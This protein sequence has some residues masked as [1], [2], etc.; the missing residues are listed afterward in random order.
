MVARDKRI[1][2]GTANLENSYGSKG[3]QTSLRISD[4]EK[5]IGLIISQ[6]G[7]SI[8]TSPDYGQ[9]ESILGKLFNGLQFDKINSKVSPENFKSSQ[10]I[11]DSVEASL[12]RLQ[13]NSLNV[14]ML[15]GGFNEILK[16]QDEIE[17]GIRKVIRLGYANRIGF[18][19]YS[20]N[21]ILEIRKLLPTVSNFQILENIADQRVIN[22]KPISNLAESGIGFQVRSIFLQGKLL[23]KN[24]AENFPDLLPILENIDKLAD[25][26]KTTRLAICLEYGRSITWAEELVVGVE[27]YEN[28]IEIQ[29]IMKAP[30]LEIVDYGKPLPKGLADPREWK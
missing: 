4:A 3:L 28:F 20:E 15:H 17:E 18:S 26:F 14:I 29:S 7:Y 22:S 19:A 21:E 11:I 25:E 30:K 6:P 13:Q 12:E 5:I 1:S 27:S 10:A 8:D 23:Q 9:A 16:F 24:A 2:V